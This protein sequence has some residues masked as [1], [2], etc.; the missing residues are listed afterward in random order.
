[1]E[2][3]KEKQEE[4]KDE[5]KKTCKLIRKQTKQTRN[6]VKFNIDKIEEE[7]SKDVATVTVTLDDYSHSN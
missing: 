2:L 7:D 6:S 1:M 4:T 5:A 3:E